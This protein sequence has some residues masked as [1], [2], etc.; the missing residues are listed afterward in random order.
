M[1]YGLSHIEE[2]YLDKNLIKFIALAPC[3]LS[4]GLVTPWGKPDI[5]SYKETYFRLQEL[6]VYAVKGP[7]WDSDLKIICDNLDEDFCTVSK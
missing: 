4:T 3:S 1:F 7:N 2:S 5:A 6:G